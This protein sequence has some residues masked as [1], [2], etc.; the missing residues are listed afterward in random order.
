[1][2]TEQMAESMRPSNVYNLPG[3]GDVE[4]VNIG[5]SNGGGVDGGGNGPQDGDMEKR[6][7]TLEGRLD[8]ILPTLASKSDIESIKTLI[9]VENTHAES[10]RAD[11]NKSISDSKNWMFGILATLT[12]FAL[13][14]SLTLYNS[15][16]SSMTDSIGALST[17]IE[18]QLAADKTP[19]P[20]P[21]APQIIIVPTTGTMM[22]TKEEDPLK[23]Y[24]PKPSGQD[25]D[26]LKQKK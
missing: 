7:S 23:F 2:G 26:S 20:T 18:Y 16:R 19:Q 15:L 5:E 8:A 4:L 11:V 14:I 9:G 17:K 12:L 21:Q 6:L 13:T 10:L 24:I 25:D 22:A 1:M 3:R